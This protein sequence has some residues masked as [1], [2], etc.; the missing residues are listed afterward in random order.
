MCGVDTKNA[1]E[2]TILFSCIFLVEKAAGCKIGIII[3]A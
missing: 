1:A 3:A 2:A